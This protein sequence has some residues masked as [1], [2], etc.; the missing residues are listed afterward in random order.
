MN[1]EE[2]AQ[3]ACEEPTLTD[4]LAWIAVWES[5]RA[6]KQALEHHKT[7]AR[8]GSNGAAWDTCFKACFKRVMKVWENDH[9]T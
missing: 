3:K 8:R 4:A 6:I 2:A 5:E 7:G 1:L 9:G